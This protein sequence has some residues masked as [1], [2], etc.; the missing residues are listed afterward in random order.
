MNY[1]QDIHIDPT[2]DCMD[3]ADSSSMLRQKFSFCLLLAIMISALYCQTGNHGCR[4]SGL[5]P[6]PLVFRLLP[7][8]S[9]NSPFH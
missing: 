3:R 4:I 7:A 8:G 2:S 9:A 6:E 1:R 5:Y